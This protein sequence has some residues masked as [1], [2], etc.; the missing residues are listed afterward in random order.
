MNDTGPETIFELKAIGVIRT[1]FK[2]KKEI[3][4]QGYRA[5]VVGEVE[6]FPEF[7][8][9]LKDIEGFSHVYLIYYFHENTG[10]EPL[11][12]P[13]LDERERGVFATRYY[14]RPNHIGI[15][16][17]RLT[18]VEGN[19]LEVAQV[20]ML[21]GTPLLD[22]KPYVPRFDHREDVRIGWLEGKMDKRQS[23]RPD[24]GKEDA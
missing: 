2:D 5:E 14:N 7:E 6:V 1:P 23:E 18:G 12:R 24:G 20:D 11:V 4:C 9:A 16:V 19:V 8:E 22:I 21:D 17:V 3:P 10:Y 15:S 13:F